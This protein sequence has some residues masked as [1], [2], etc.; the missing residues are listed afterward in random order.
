MVKENHAKTW[1]N[2]IIMDILKFL[3]VSI[4][5]M[6]DDSALIYCNTSMKL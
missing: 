6:K 1:L 5:K 3:K 2:S 4:V